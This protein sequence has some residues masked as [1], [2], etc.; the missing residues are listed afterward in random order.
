MDEDQFNTRRKS[1]LKLIRNVTT[2]VSE[3]TEAEVDPYDVETG[4]INER[5]SQ[6]R[7]KL[8]LVTDQAEF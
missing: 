8:Q 2:A 5:L 6:I 4:G 3:Y 1:L 7:A